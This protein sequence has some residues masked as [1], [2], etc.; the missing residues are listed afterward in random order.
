MYGARGG[1]GHERLRR[2]LWRVN[3]V[4]LICF[5][6]YETRV[7]ARL[8]RVR[9]TNYEKRA[10]ISDN[11]ITFIWVT[12]YFRE[13]WIS[14]RARVTRQWRVPVYYCVN[15]FCER[16][17]AAAAGRS[18]FQTSYLRFYILYSSSSRAVIV[19]SLLKTHIS[20]HLHDPY[21]LYRSGQA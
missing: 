18:I 14:Y 11:N 7:N 8:S 10:R 20:V 6:S 12:R 4:W 15:T 3:A 9:R 13:T 21:T 1:R 16:V 2:P 5:R 19:V 17:A